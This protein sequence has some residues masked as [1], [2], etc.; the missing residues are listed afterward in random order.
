MAKYQ[1]NFE[2]DTTDGSEMIEIRNP[3][4]SGKNLEILKI[5]VVAETGFDVYD[6]QRFDALATHAV[7]PDPEPT[8]ADLFKWNPTHAAPVGQVW[9]GAAGSIT[10]GGT[11]DFHHDVQLDASDAGDDA[12]VIFGKYLDGEQIVMVPG[13][14]ARWELPLNAQANYWIQILWQEVAT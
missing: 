12:E 4:G 2:I 8:Q 10:F 7:A 14:S 1:T 13:T 9:F 3:S 6:F 5:S 11:M